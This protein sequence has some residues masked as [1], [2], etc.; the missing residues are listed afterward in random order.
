MSNP[1]WIARDSTP[2]RVL[3]KKFHTQKIVFYRNFLMQEIER[4]QQMEQ[5]LDKVSAAQK[6]LS[7]ALAQFSGVQPQLCKL[8]Q[9]YGSAA[10]HHDLGLDEQGKLPKDLKRGV[11]SED[12]VY[13]LL[14]DLHTMVQ[15]MRET[16]DCT[17]KNLK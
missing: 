5:A 17:L 15:E 14:S 9:Y 7:E 2:W 12:A 16:A 8:F 10:F 6:K 3:G 11:L 1:L 4:I 13:D